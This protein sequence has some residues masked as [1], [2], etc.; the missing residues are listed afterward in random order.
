MTEIDTSRDRIEHLR[1]I[2]CADYL[3]MALLARAEK[4]EAERDTARRAFAEALK[5]ST[6]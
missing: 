4:A 1:S 6:K 5:E 2:D 3:H